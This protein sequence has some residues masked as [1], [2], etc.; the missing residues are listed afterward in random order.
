MYLVSTHADR[1]I[2][3]V[4]RKRDGSDI[5]CSVSHQDLCEFASNLPSA[6]SLSGKVASTGMS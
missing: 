1:T 4:E 5:F 6:I 2:K 3:E